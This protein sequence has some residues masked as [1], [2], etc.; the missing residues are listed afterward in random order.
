M[1]SASKTPIARV[2]NL[3]KLKTVIV[4]YSYFHSSNLVIIRIKYVFCIILK[5]ENMLKSMRKIQEII[6]IL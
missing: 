2:N 3:T 5:I 1:R 4:Y 6:N